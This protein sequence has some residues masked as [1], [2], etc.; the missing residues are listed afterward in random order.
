MERV[1][2]E[3]MS[4]EV[5]NRNC[6]SS[7]LV[8]ISSLLSK[9]L[10]S[11]QSCNDDKHARNV[12]H[13]EACKIS[14]DLDLHTHIARASHSGRSGCHFHHLN[15]SI[16]RFEAASSAAIASPCLG[17]GESFIGPWN[18][19]YNLIGIQPITLCRLK[20]KESTTLRGQGAIQGHVVLSSGQF[21]LEFSE[22]FQQV[23]AGG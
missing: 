22:G 7:E 9:T 19:T 5:S 6:S 11:I 14:H 12:T 3:S 8:L 2:A 20:L 16:F 4:T 21:E 18:S 17:C 13:I 1:P 10:N 23:G 15:S